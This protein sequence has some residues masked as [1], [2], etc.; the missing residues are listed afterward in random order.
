MAASQACRSVSVVAGS[1][2]TRYRFVVLAAG[3]G[4]YDMVSGA[5]GEAD[6]IAGESVSA[7][8]SLA[9]VLPDH[10]IAKVEAGDAVSRGAVVGSD[11]SG[12]AIP[13]VSGAGNFRLG[14]AR[15]AATA[16][17]DIIEI[18]FFKEL[19]QVT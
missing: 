8:D 17:G 14:K 2:V 12:R 1:T 4:Q 9:M 15:E 3:D 5:Q 13:A 16:A 19:D 6:G 18:E 11:T 10:G 7:G